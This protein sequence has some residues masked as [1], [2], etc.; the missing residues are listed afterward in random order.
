M[1]QNFIKNR[2]KILAKRDENIRG[3]ISKY[4]IALIINEYDTA[5]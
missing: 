2:A 1:I 4:A 3:F 5:M